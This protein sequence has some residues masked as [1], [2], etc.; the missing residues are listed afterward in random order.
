MRMSVRAAPEGARRPCSQSCSVRTD[1]PSSRAKSDC[2]NPVRSRTPATAGNFVT[3]PCC[4]RLISRMPSR[5]SR[6]ILRFVL[7]INFLPDLAQN[8]RGDAVRF[9]LGINRQ[10]PDLA[11]VGAGEINYANPSTLAATGNAPSKLADSTVP[12]TT[13]PARGSAAKAHCKAPYSS[14]LRYALTRRVK[15]FVSMNVSTTILYGSAVY[16]QGDIR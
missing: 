13:S 14:S 2:D 12:R 5:I 4:P 10:H 3:R 11:L 9:V 16:R 6:P 1:T 7:A 15:S 8:V